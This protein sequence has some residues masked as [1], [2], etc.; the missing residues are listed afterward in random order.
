M[1]SLQERED[2][3]WKALAHATRRQI[4][5]VLF[6]APSTTG[7]VVDALALDRHVVMAHLAVLRD[8]DLV[9]TEKL[10]RVRIN[11]LNPVPIQGIHHRW[12]TSTSGPWAAALI[13]VRDE[14]ERA[15]A[16]GIPQEETPDDWKQSG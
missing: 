15:S 11:Y 8:A 12:I 4:L 5:D 14:A 9:S 2:R 1:N 6:E 16:Q 13:A 10:G 3:V 7:E